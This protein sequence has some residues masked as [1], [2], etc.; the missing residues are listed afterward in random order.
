[1]S[2]DL[3]QYQVNNSTTIGSSMRSESFIYLALSY[4][5]ICRKYN[6]KF[7]YYGALVVTSI[8]DR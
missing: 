4:Q 6:A 5:A 8:V 3:N 7:K 2:M 1:M